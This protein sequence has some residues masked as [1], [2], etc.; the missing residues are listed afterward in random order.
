MGGL[1]LD[2]PS[3]EAMTALRQRVKAMGVPIDGIPDEMLIDGA[4]QRMDAFE[5]HAPVSAAEAAT[6]MLDAVRDERWRVLIG[7]D[8]A[9]LDKAV[10]G[11]PE[12]AYERSF[13]ERIAHL[14]KSMR[15]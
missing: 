10:R 1:D 8:A 9:E 14:G 7:E 4:R 11:F 12:E 6:V 2:N 13:M 15:G 3:K 5:N